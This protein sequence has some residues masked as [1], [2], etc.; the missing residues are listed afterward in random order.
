MTHK[1]LSYVEPEDKEDKE[2][3]EEQVV[4]VVVALGLQQLPHIPDCVRDDQTGSV[5]PIVNVFEKWL[6]LLHF[7]PDVDGKLM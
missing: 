2:A 5:E 4:V 7:H 6:L 3:E 1:T